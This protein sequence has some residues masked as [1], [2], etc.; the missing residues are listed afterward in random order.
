MI[1]LLIPVMLSAGASAD[2][3]Y[4]TFHY[5]NHPY[6]KYMGHHPGYV[7]TTPKPEMK[8]DMKEMKE[9]AHMMMKP[10]KEEPKPPMHM[11]DMPY[12][13]APAHHHQ[14]APPVQPYH[15][16]PYHAPQPYHHPVAHVR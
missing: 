13:H 3:Q 4:N 15:H 14:Y 7:V 11:H 2:S 9:P 16:Q 10:M 6:I 5:A 12:H 8:H 1:L